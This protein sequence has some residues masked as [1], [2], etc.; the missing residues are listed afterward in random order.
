V[1]I[2]FQIARQ[3]FI[4]MCLISILIGISFSERLKKKSENHSMNILGMF[5]HFKDAIVFTSRL[6]CSLYAIDIT[7]RRH[8]YHTTPFD[9]KIVIDNQFLYK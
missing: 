5:S 9:S 7:Q 2:D 3:S 6:N 4:K 8:N 1:Y